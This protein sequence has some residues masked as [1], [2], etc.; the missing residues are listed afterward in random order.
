MIRLASKEAINVFFMVPGE[1]EI[2]HYDE[3]ENLYHNTFSRHDIQAFLEEREDVES[4]IWTFIVEGEI[5][6]IINKKKPSS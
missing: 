4:Y 6:L 5:G 3:V 1:E 2:I